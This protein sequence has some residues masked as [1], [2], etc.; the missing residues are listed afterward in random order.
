MTLRNMKTA[1]VA[2]A[3][4]LAFALPAHAATPPAPAASPD[5]LCLAAYLTMAG[6]A[7]EATKNAG[8][9]GALFYAGKVE[10]AN[11]GKD[12][13]DF[14]IALFN[15]P[16]AEAKITAAMPR[17]GQELQ[18]LGRHWIERGAEFQRSTAPAQ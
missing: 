8:L 5:T 2:S 17:C 1:L 4:L 7:D 18:V 9:M 6:S 13:L 16:D 10:G 14:V 3:T 15:Q 12:S 11:P